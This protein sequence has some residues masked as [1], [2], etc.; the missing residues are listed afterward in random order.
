M[1]IKKR[2][3]MKTYY[4]I[5]L[6][7]SALVSLVAA[8]DQSPS[9]PAEPSGDQ[10]F[11]EWLNKL[12]GLDDWFISMDGKEQ[13][14]QVVDALMRL[15]SPD[16]IQFVGPN[17]KQMGLVTLS[18]V[19]AIQKWADEMARTR[20]QI[21]WR[22]VSRTLDEKTAALLAV[23]APWGGVSVSSEITF[24]FTDRY[25]DRRFQIPGTVLVDFGG[26]GK[27]RRVR[28]YLL[29]DEMEEIFPYDLL[30]D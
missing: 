10:L 27:I 8:Q 5:F 18:G 1:Y 30:G 15:Y 11:N 9:K 25:T 4:C 16:A 12:N 3:M 7:L 6:V 28:L 13:P 14:E 20:R 24:A 23:P 17:E 22:V 26:D 19:E 2:L 29:K 21:A